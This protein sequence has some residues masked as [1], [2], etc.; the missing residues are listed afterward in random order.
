[1]TRGCSLDAY[2]GYMSSKGIS[3]GDL[4]AIGKIKLSDVESYMNA[5]QT[6]EKNFL[7]VRVFAKKWEGEI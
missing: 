2:M 1:M 3:L 5:N 4:G 7:A 6:D